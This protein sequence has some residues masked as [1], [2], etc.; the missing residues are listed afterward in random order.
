MNDSV[1]NINET[2]IIEG[3]SN[4]IPVISAC[5]GLYS[6]E[7]ISCTGDTFITLGNGVINFN[8]NL[9]TNDN[10]S[11]NT[12]NASTYLSG[13]T[14][15]FNIIQLTEITG[16]T[17]NSNSG[18]LSLKKGNDTSV[19]IS[20]INNYYTTGAT[21]VGNVAYFNRND[22][23]SAYTL[24]LTTLIP[25]T[26]FDVFVTGGTYSNGT[27]I[28]TNNTGG[29]FS[30]SGF[31]TGGTGSSIF[32]GGTVTG[33][34]NFTGGLSANTFSA[35]TYQNLPLD[36]RVTGGTYSSSAGTATFTNNTGGTFSVSGLTNNLITFKRVSSS[37]TLD[38]TDLVSVNSGQNLV[39]EMSA[40]STN[41]LTIP[42]N[43]AVT[44]SIGTS[45][46]VSQYSSFQTTITAGSGV[47]LRSSGGF[48]KL[49]AQYS[50][51][52]LLKVGTNEWYVIGQLAP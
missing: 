21:L 46:D 37:Y 7:L 44:F 50:F 47:T 17:Y 5:T 45:I 11:A 9:Y 2:F 18:I 49:A 52:T 41:T 26:P 42:P 13:G 24:N 31:S 27:T 29:T 6:N 48:L 43:S 19:N 1:Y 12:I 32:T 15:L 34:T 35:T 14:N 30:I 3:A 28:F 8:G 51:C 23:L 16:G 22:A 38:G 36:V 20:G 40:S 25:P 39:I 4:D 10:L 33:P